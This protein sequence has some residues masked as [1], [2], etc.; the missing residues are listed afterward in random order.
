MVL[1][2]DGIESGFGRGCSALEVTSRVVDPMADTEDDPVVP[3][4]RIFYTTQ[5]V[6][7]F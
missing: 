4:D 2:E 5:T 3:E 1:S 7:H 6:P